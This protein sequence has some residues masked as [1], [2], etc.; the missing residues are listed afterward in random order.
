MSHYFNRWFN[1]G[2]K[3]EHNLVLVMKRCG[4]LAFVRFIKWWLIPYHYLWFGLCQFISDPHLL[5]FIVHPSFS[6]GC[7]LHLFGHPRQLCVEHIPVCSRADLYC[8]PKWMPFHREYIWKACRLC[9]FGHDHADCT[10]LGISWDKAYTIKFDWAF[11]F[12]HSF[13]ELK[14]TRPYPVSFLQTISSSIHLDALIPSN[15]YV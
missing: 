1:N 2:L 11:L 15:R 8:L 9:G 3:R 7:C 14:N 10:A 5:V 13:Y 6:L 12:L 4:T